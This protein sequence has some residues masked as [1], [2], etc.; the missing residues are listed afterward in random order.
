MM[1]GFFAAFGARDPLLGRMCSF[2]LE[3]GTHSPIHRLA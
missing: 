1:D 3:V 2:Y